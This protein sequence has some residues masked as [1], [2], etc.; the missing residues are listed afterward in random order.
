L[1]RQV[2]E[3]ESDGRKPILADYISAAMTIRARHKGKVIKAVVRKTGHI[4][5]DGKQFTSPS[6]A[7]AHAVKRPT[8]NGWTF[9]QFER[10]PGDWVPLDTLRK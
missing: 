3:I 9:W 4:T 10:A 6:L 8:C 7:G 2:V 1:A 5:F